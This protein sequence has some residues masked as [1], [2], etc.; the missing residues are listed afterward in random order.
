MA[1]EGLAAAAHE[2][3]AVLVDYDRTHADERRLGKLALD[4]LH[5]GS[6]KG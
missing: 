2:E 6:L 3:H 4:F 1:F 5:S